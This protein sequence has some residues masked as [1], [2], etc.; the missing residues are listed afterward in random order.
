MSITSLLEQKML[1]LA[2]K[3]SSNIYLTA[4]KNAFIALIP[5]LIVG[6]F[7]Q[8]VSFGANKSDIFIP[9]HLFQNYHILQPHPHYL[10]QV[11]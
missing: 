11:T 1:P 6:S 4:L 7:F 8:L 2:E 10:N 9:I 5:F 3:I